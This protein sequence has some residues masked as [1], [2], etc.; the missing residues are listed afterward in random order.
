MVNRTIGTRL[1]ERRALAL[2]RV[3]EA[4]QPGQQLT[5]KRTVDTVVWQAP[6]HSERVSCHSE[7]SEESLVR[8][9]TLPVR[10]RDSS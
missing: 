4:L 5:V 1:Q 8:P 9:A 3:V 10:P 6:C 7:R 2:I